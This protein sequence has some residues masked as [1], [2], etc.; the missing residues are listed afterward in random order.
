MRI[1]DTKRQLV[2]IIGLVAVVAVAVI[3]MT[4]VADAATSSSATV[5]IKDIDFKPTRV[6]IRRGGSVRWL[7]MDGSTPHNV[8]SVGKRRFRSSPTKQ[9]GSYRAT[10]KRAGSYRYVCTI[11]LNMKGTV[12][13]R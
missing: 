8:R 10:F 9:S 6:V 12:V 4:R 13:V 3:G 1:A 5:R 2:V 11:H 7:F